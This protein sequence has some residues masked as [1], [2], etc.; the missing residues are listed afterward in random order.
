MLMTDH[1][2]LVPVQQ[3]G[4]A[5]AYNLGEESSTANGHLESFAFGYGYIRATIQAAER[6]G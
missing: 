3:P 4:G 1:V 5:Y 6:F 2:P